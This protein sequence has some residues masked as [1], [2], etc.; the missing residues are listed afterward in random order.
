MKIS[1]VIPNY[2]GASLLKE[3]IPFV[4]KAG[5]YYEKKK[6]VPFEIVITDDASIDES[7]AVVT[8]FSFP[9]SYVKHEK[10]AGFSTN[11]NRGVHHAS[12]D[13][14]V[15]LNS[16]V[17]PEEAFLEPLLKH[18]SDDTLF[19]VGCL[20]E[21]VEQGKIKKRGRGLGSF[22]KGFLIHRAGDVN[23]HATL[24]VSGGSSA[25]RKAY[26][27]KLGGFYPIYNPFYWEDIDLSYRAVKAGYTIRFEPESIVRHEHDLG[28]IKKQFVK[29]KINAVAYRNQFLFVWLN[30]T[31]KV[32][33]IQH[34]MWLPVHSIKA[35]VRLD[36]AFWHGFFS[37]LRLLPEVQRIR[38]KNNKLFILSDETV[39]QDVK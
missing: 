33:V 5:K 31:A 18:F 10:N 7:E 8:S 3:N 26:F 21:S 34:I 19:A 30:I 12:G 16:D 23:T 11:V 25:F 37:A 36:K 35:V 24:W 4:Y 39:L 22:R 2:N 27:E 32:Y 13:I 29:S 15:L 17:R 38:K 9:V 14:V 1:F 6:Q 20:D 28:A